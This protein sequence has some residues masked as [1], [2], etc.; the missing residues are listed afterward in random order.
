MQ[1]RESAAGER[2]RLGK[3]WQQR[4]Q[5]A[6]YDV[7]LAERR[8]Q[9]D[10]PENRLVAA[11]LEKHWEDALCEERQLHEEHDRFLRETPPQLSR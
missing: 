1:A 9:A 3:H 2:K 4:L 11:T 7:E 8:Y 10:D 5:R 6:R